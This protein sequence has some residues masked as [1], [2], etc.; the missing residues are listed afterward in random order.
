MPPETRTPIVE[1][2]TMKTFLKIAL[3]TGALAL[4]VAPALALGDQPS[5]VPPSNQGTALI[6]AGNG[7]NY[8][9]AP[10]T[11]GPKAG[12]PAQAKA[13]GRYCNDESRQHVAGQPGTPFSQCVTAMAK[14]ATNDSL[15][16][17]QACKGTSKKHVKGEKGT[18][19]S[20]CVTAAAK[21]RRHQ[22]G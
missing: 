17:G 8:T 14:A 1:G 19:F 4:S 15:S 12:L 18:P 22:H 16:P 2:G 10:P 20:R 7:P 11:P 6:P 3:A 9:P 5:N 21:L 13:Y